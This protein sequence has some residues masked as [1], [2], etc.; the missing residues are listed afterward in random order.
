MVNVGRCAG[1]WIIGRCVCG[2]GGGGDSGSTRVA[3]LCCNLPTSPFPA[4]SSLFP[5]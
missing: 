4:S 1:G 2:V 5:L 3:S